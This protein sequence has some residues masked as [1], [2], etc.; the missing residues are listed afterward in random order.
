MS[1][2]AREE[3]PAAHNRQATVD[4][5]LRNKIVCICTDALK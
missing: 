2:R 4:A 3:Q 1:K 5:A